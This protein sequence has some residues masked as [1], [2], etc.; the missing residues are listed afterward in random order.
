MSSD[1]HRRYGSVFAALL[2]G[3]ALATLVFTLGN[4]NGPGAADVAASGKLT[5]ADVKDIRADIAALR[6]QTNSLGVSPPV[7]RSDA[8]PPSVE[9]AEILARLDILERELLQ[10]RENASAGVAEA[11]DNLVETLRVRM[12]ER[13]AGASRSYARGEELFEKDYETARGLR[14][15]AVEAAFSDAPAKFALQEVSCRSSICKITYRLQSP[16]E[17]SSSAINASNDFLVNGISAAY[18]GVDLDVL[19]GTDQYGNQVLYIQER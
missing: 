17:L 18:G 15:E 12:Q 19:R 4:R 1:G 7:Q 14:E 2:L 11:D 10:L 13:G 3:A 5:A 16:E 9:T 6:A 8:E